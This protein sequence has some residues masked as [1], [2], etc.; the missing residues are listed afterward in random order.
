MRL[1][2]KSETKTINI[3]TDT[4]VRAL[5]LTVVLLILLKVVGNISHQLTLIGVSFFLALALNPAVSWI[6]RRLKSRSRVRATGFAYII[7]MGILITFLA[8]FVPPLVRQT[9][10]YVR[11][12]PETI[13]NIQ[14]EDT[15]VG[16]FV[17][18]YDLS[19]QLEQWSDDLRERTGDLKDPLLNTASRALG[20][21]V[22]VIT[23]L[24]LTFMMLVEGPVWVEWAM[25]LQPTEKRKRRHELAM[26]M[27]KVVTGYV[28]GQVLI[29]AMAAF[30][31]MIAILI[32]NA[33][34]DASVNAVAMAGITF[35]FALIPLIGNVIGAAI[36]ALMCLFQSVPFAIAIGVYYLIYQQIEN[37][38]L[39][40]YIQSRSNQLTPLIV[41]IAAL[42]G[43]GLGGLL[44][45][46]AA[47]PVAGCIRILV[48]DYIDRRLPDSK[49]VEEAKT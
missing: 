9:T 33:V 39:Q 28:N 35:I 24:V 19:E 14:S 11:T 25:A 18:R 37:I 30:F 23:V 26:R 49:V 48:E 44:G 32:G 31:A 40:P 5:S 20:T 42:L 4:V 38:T 36:V 41:F 3:S 1:F 29:A 21:L 17:R 45:A 46:L 7:V 43:A 15:P 6:T 12:L 2:G 8:L 34:F 10:D 22:S 47:I 27:Y 13:D 16:R